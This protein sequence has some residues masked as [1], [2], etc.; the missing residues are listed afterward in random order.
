MRFTTLNNP[1]SRYNTFKHATVHS[2]HTLPACRRR[3]VHNFIQLLLQKDNEFSYSTGHMSVPSGVLN[4]ESGTS[5]LFCGNGAVSRKTR[6]SVT[7]IHRRWLRDE[8]LIHRMSCCFLFAVFQSC[9]RFNYVYLYRSRVDSI[10][11]AS[12]FFLFRMK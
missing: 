7:H 12:S 9:G 10:C 1:T 3:L 4:R 11:H 6:S 2:A 8:W 5:S